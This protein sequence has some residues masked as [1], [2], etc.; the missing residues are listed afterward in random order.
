MN[1]AAWPRPD[2]LAERLLCIDPA[3][4]EVE[5][6]RVA[7]LPS[8]LSAGD[9]L[10]VNDAATLPAS[11]QA[12]PI[13]LRLAGQRADGTFSAVLFGAGDWRTPTENRPAPPELR[14]GDEI[15]FDGG[16]LA[17]VE[18]VSEVSPR[19]VVVRFADSGAALWAGLYRAG[20]PV[21]Y[22]YTAG[23]L[24]LWHTQTAYAGR[25]WAME[26]PS[27]GRPLTH[28]LLAALRARGVAI[29]P[30]THAAG[31]SSTGDAALDAMLPFPE[32]YEIPAATVRAIA[33]AKRV[34]AVGT[35][36][37]RALEG[38]AEPP[39][40]S[41]SPDGERKGE[42]H[43]SLRAGPGETDLRLG[44]AHR[45]RVVCGLLTGIHDPTASHF[46]L[47]QAFAPAELL[48]RAYA[49]AERRGYLGHEFGDLN[50]IIRR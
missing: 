6:A 19:L 46:E 18:R 4:G 34:I 22:A 20:R 8:R 41:P 32:R 37:T 30:L 2:P 10:V 21:Q 45:L 17:T 13:E 48:R 7:D 24:P 3:S 29:A 28:G 5:D 27:A 38:A 50:L 1:P 14:A 26:Q 11:L 44:P 39:R 12:G 9:L 31:L 47:L 33:E 16:M 25:P 36:V 35:S 42:P 23:P 49:G 15:R 43:G 40:P